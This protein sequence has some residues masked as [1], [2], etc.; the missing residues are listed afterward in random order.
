MEETGD[1]CYRVSCDCLSPG[2][3]SEFDNEAN[4]DKHIRTVHKTDPEDGL[5]LIVPTD[6]AKC[7]HPRHKKEVE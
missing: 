6:K 4:A 7:L 2:F 5:M 1:K 3:Y